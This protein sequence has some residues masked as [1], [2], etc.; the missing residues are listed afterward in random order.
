MGGI[1]GLALG[2]IYSRAAA[3][4]EIWPAIGWI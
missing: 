2:R 4:H 3:A 1:D